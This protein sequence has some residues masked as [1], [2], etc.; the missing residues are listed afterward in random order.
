MQKGQ[1]VNGGRCL[2]G[3]NDIFVFSKKDRKRVWKEHMEKTMNKE[4]AW[5][6]NNEIGTMEGP[7]EEVSLE[8]ITIAMKKMKFEKAS[9]LS[10]VSM[11]MINASGKVGIYVMKLCQKVH[12]GKG[13]LKDWKISVM[14]PIYIRKGDVTNCGA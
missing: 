4:N 8:E 1:D 11:E 9:G 5:D 10:E 7:V 12:D 6:Q 14:V 2:R 3:I 13:M